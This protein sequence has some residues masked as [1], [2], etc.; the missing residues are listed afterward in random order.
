[1][2]I[3]SEFLILLKYFLKNLLQFSLSS[4]KKGTPTFETFFNGTNNFVLHSK[5]L[6]WENGSDGEEMNFGINFFNQKNIS[7]FL[8]ICAFVQLVKESII[9]RPYDT[10]EDYLQG[11]FPSGIVKRSKYITLIL[12][13]GITPDIN[14]NWKIFNLLDY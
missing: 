5:P 12:F 1:M 8:N 11:S 4:I 3:Q 7:W 10:Y 9:N 6:G 14:I 2:L 13:W